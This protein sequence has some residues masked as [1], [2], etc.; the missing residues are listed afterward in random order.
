MSNHNHNQHQPMKKLLTI[1]ATILA[2]AF[3]C[4]CNA[5]KNELVGTWLYDIGRAK[6]TLEFQSN[7]E[8][9]TIIS[10]IENDQESGKWM[11]KDD[12]IIL[13]TTLKNGEKKATPKERT[14]KILKVTPET[15]T[16]LDNEDGDTA[17][18][19]RL[20]KK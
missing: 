9:N 11:R 7:G 16:M 6:I 13:T 2:F 8:F 3:L 15:L 17:T 18:F 5:K 20:G 12:V 14:L 4:G 1:T 10:G 19:I